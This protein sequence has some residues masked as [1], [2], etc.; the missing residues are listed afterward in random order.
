MVA[1]KRHTEAFLSRISWE[2]AFAVL[3][4]PTWVWHPAKG[5]INRA[6][7]AL[8]S[9]VA[10]IVARHRTERA[11][12][13]AAGDLLGR[14]IAAR[15]P[16]TGEAMDDARLVDN[17]LTLLEAGHETTAKALT[18]TLYLLAR[19]PAT[20]DRVRAE[21]RAVAGDGP[22]GAE[23][24]ARLTLTE[25]VL[26]EGMRLYPPAPVLLRIARRPLDLGGEHLPTGAL[27]IIPV[28]ALHRHRT[29]WDD[30]DRF[31]PERFLSEAARAMPR[32]QYM[33]FGGGPRVCIGA[34]FAMQEAI[35][36][37]ATLIRGARFAWDGRHLPEPISRI[38][39][40]PKGGM[41]LRVTAI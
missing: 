28:F 3:N 37:L 17:L 1:I 25:A 22:V 30:P 9:T 12:K 34:T 29:L 41:P 36:I 5:Q 23:H 26:K 20:Q 6:S 8:R 27:L 16:E 15:D 31:M 24:L 33:P 13:P 21:V 32:T 40:R 18:W 2:V 19:A 14:L 4:F 7:T 38:T 35:A 10:G 39:L 11:G